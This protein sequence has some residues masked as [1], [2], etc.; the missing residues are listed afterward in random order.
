MHTEADLSSLQREQTNTSASHSQL[1][2]SETHA[3]L[4]KQV[5]STGDQRN[6]HEDQA[7]ERGSARSLFGLLK[8]NIHS[9][10]KW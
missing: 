4:S 9:F 8:G 3:A 6:I 1:P 7:R 2:Q 5:Q 10:N